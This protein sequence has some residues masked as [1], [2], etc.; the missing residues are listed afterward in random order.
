MKTLFG[1]TLGSLLGLS[2]ALCLVFALLSVTLIGQIHTEINDKA[3][4]ETARLLS[5]YLPDPADA[6]E[7][8]GGRGLI[9][10]AFEDQTQEPF[11]QE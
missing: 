11:R 7:E 1:K 2:L 8:C 6:A 5:A 3:L 9:A 4:A 10:G